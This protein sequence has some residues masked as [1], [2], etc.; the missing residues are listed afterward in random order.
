MADEES[1]SVLKVL[2]E[3]M[4]EVTEPLHKMSEA[5]EE[6]ESGIWDLT[7]AFASVYLGYELLEHLIEPAAEFQQAQLSLAQATSASSEALAE[8]KEQAEGLSETLPQSLNDITDAQT[9][10]FQSFQSQDVAEAGARQAAILSTV[11]GIKPA[12]AANDLATA[13]QNLGDQTKDPTARMQDMS[14]KLA[15]L[16][17]QFPLGSTEAGRL[18]MTLGRIGPI[19][20]Q[21]GITTTPIFATLG[22]MSRLGIGGPRGPGM[23]LGNLFEQILKAD[24]KTGISYL[25]KL[26]GT[27]VHTSEA[28]NKANHLAPGS[29]NWIETLQGLN[30]LDPAKL[31]QLERTLG[32][33]GGTLGTLISK[34]PEL[35]G[36]YDK[37][38]N[39]Q[40]A[41]Q[42]AAT[43]RAA[44]FN[45]QVTILKNSIE[46]LA[47]ALGTRMIPS[48][49]K[50]VDVLTEVIKQV[51]AFVDAHPILTRIFTTVLLIGAG[52]LTVVASI[53][54]V[55]KVIKFLASGWHDLFEIVEPVI[56]L[57][58]EGLVGALEGATVAAEGFGVSLAAALGIVSGIILAVG[59]AVGVVYELWKH[60]DMVHE[61][62]LDILETLHEVFTLGAAPGSF[63]DRI[64]DMGLP[65]GSNA[66]SE[67]IETRAALGNTTINY[68]PTIHGWD[69]QEGS[70]HELMKGHSSDLAAKLDDSHRRSMRVG[71]GDPQT[72]H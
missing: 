55:G 10:M 34:L 64:W 28:F 63:L 13:V 41:A 58:G 37:F 7:Q 30:K 31:S 50:F 17:T 40:G 18:G 45:G 4:D 23:L 3:L 14:D 36:T 32:V 1:Q 47:E 20:R 2:V 59:I 11:L 21:F 62:I 68:A 57:M 52:M 24:P 8:Y 5:F 72:A 49:T 66:S 42:K 71:F 46:N 27:I 29:V 22:E 38:N 61:K 19:A 69:G 16:K 15:V 44:T 48:L 6:F 65:T 67:S 12:Q 9:R 51:V 26:G 60:W 70:L 43:E 56:D 35:L 53:G 25:Q 39:A 54:L 33:P